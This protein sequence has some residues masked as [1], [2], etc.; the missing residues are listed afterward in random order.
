MR[1]VTILCVQSIQ[2]SLLFKQKYY[3]LHLTWYC[4]Y[5][6]DRT[7]VAGFFLNSLDY[8]YS[9]L[10]DILTLNNYNKLRIYAEQN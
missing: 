8:I 10:T 6:S 7:N 5:R 3:L 4:Q 2:N 9:R 1:K